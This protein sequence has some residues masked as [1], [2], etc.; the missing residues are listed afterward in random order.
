MI[1]ILS[2]LKT[3]ALP[4]IMRSVE[5]MNLY[6]NIEYDFKYSPENAHK[7]I[8]VWKC[9]LALLQFGS[10]WLIVLLG[11]ITLFMWLLWSDV[12][13][14]CGITEYNIVNKCVK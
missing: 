7:K 5:G 8:Y 6:E 11:W 9:I 14:I 1:L 12:F 10:T 4:I 13:C 3:K 2:I